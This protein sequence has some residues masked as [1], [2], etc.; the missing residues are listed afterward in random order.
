MQCV[1]LSVPHVHQGAGLDGMDCVGLLIYAFEASSETQ[2][3]GRD[4][5]AGI[6]ERRLQVHFGQPVHRRGATLEML[7]DGDV[8]A[9]RWGGDPRHVGLVQIVDGVRYLIHSMQAPGHV[10]RHSIDDAWIRMIRV[11]YRPEYDE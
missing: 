4:P 1:D 5:H 9:M 10:A 8:V 6:L 3:Y 11:V 7:Q 2:D